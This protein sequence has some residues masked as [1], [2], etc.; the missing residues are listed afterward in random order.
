MKMET[1][2]HSRQSLCCEKYGAKP[3]PVPSHLKVGIARNVREGLQPLNGLRIIPEGDTTGW[4]IWAGTQW[5]DDPDFFMPLH[6]EHLPSWCAA[7]I[8]YLQ[9][10]PG[11][12]FLLAPGQEDVWF[13]AKL[14][15][16]KTRTEE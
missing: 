8:P 5:P 6:V 16:Q 13:D 15:E 3:M 11:W 10:P 7:A 1:D 14:V 9:L 2:W 12:R 4:Y